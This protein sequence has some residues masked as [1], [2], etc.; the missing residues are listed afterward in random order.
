MR[1]RFRRTS[2]ARL[3]VMPVSQV[4]RLERPSNRFMLSSTTIQVS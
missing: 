4:S 3:S 2:F 1:D